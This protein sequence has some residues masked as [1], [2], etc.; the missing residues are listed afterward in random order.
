MKKTALIIDSDKEYLQKIKEMFNDVFDTLTYDN[1]EDGL[2]EAYQNKDIVFIFV[3]SL[4][5]RE[6]IIGM[7]EELEKISDAYII[8]LDA[9]DKEEHLHNTMHFNNFKYDIIDLIKDFIIRQKDVDNSF[10][11]FYAN[12]G[13][14]IKVFKKF[15]Y[16]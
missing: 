5:P 9:Y 3:G 8:V 4:N 6:N 1:K 15:S 12:W 16:T 11:N 2:L 7:K 10:R 13:K 14:L